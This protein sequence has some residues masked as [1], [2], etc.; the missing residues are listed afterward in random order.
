MQRE[1]REA[2]D[3]S[4]EMPP[5][6]RFLIPVRIDATEPSHDALREIQWVDM[7][8]DYE[9]GLHSILA[10]L[11]PDRDPTAASD[12]LIA[13]VRGLTNVN[14]APVSQGSAAREGTSAEVGGPLPSRRDLYREAIRLVQ[15]A[16]LDDQIRATASL[17]DRTE[18]LDSLFR[19]YLH[20][21]VE[22]CRAAAEASRKLAHH[23]LFAFRR[24]SVG[25]I[26]EGI[27]RG[28]DLRV[29]LFSV[30]GISDRI[31]LYQVDDDAMLDM[32]LVGR[33][34]AIIAFPENSKSSHLRY[35]I[36]AVGQQTVLS[37]VNWYE[38][39]IKDKAISLSGELGIRATP[40]A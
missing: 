22:R 38:A 27:R 15:T 19:E 30:N 10:G 4:L 32:L 37:L 9:R 2:L 11:A 16:N 24:D 14:I 31:H 1:V 23:A 12:R 39:T 33:D 26:P 21:I 35:G 18:S 34:R 5:E 25:A 8:A 29:E 13:Q 28:L 6:R 40:P 17:F 7:Y 20:A 36:S 3:R